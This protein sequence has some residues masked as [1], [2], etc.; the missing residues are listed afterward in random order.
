MAAVRSDSIDGAASSPLTSTDPFA[1]PTM[2]RFSMAIS[3]FN[4]HAR[5][6]DVMR[7]PQQAAFL[8]C[9]GDK[10]QGAWKAIA[11]GDRCPRDLDD[12]GRA[13]RVVVRSVVDF[14]RLLGHGQSAPEADVIV[15]GAD[16]DGFLRPCRVAA[17]KHANHVPHGAAVLREVLGVIDLRVGQIA[18]SG[19]EVAVDLARGRV[20]LPRIDQRLRID[21][22]ESQHRNPVVLGIRIAAEQSV[23]RIVH[24]VGGVADDEQH[25]CAL[26]ARGGG[27]RRERRLRHRAG[28]VQAAVAVSAPAVRG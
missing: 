4:R 28:A 17:R 1:R 11:V 6:A 26:A 10:D 9:E 24:L 14:P 23:R 13:R 2:S 21:A 7:R 20:E 19:H 18:R 16:D 8:A 22:P 15:V 3:V 12:R 5:R 27:L 25:L